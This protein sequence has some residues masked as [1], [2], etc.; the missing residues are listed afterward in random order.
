MPYNRLTDY[1]LQVQRLTKSSMLL[2]A[3][4]RTAGFITSI[5]NLLMYFSQIWPFGCGVT[6]GE[7]GGKVRRI[8][9]WRFRYSDTAAGRWWWV[10]AFAQIVA[11]VYNRWTRNAPTPPPT[12]WKFISASQFLLQPPN[13]HCKVFIE[14]ASLNHLGVPT[15]PKSFN[16]SLWDGSANQHG[17]SL[18]GS[19]Q[20]SSQHPSPLVS[21]TTP[22]RKLW[23]Q[24]TITFCGESHESL[25]SDLSVQSE[26]P[27][28]TWY[29]QN[30][31]V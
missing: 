24:F 26:T 20:V 9:E 15:N 4:V 28:S 6:G 7:C 2:S 21:W 1:S 22:Y 13:C 14:H 5:S 31:F 10:V 27:F 17:G 29:N 12:A 3:P 30:Q 23:K 19:M 16:P 8:R 18:I 25:E 11:T